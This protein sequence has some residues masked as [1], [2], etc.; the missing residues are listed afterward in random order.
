MNLV[1][2]GAKQRAQVLAGLFEQCPETG[3]FRLN[4]KKGSVLGNFE[5]CV[6][7]KQDVDLEF[8]SADGTV[9]RS[10]WSHN[11]RYAIDLLRCS[12]VHRFSGDPGGST[13]P[14]G[15]PEPLELSDDEIRHLNN[16]IFY[17]DP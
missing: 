11:G 14:I 2:L 8:C 13:T 7:N 5:K 17:T 6:L 9:H 12:I 15:I 10:T 16:E 3:G 1:L 4:L